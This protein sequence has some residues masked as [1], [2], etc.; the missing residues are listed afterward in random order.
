[1]LLATVLD[2][3]C[4]DNTVTLMKKPIAFG[5][6]MGAYTFFFQDCP[7]LLIHLYFLVFMHDPA[8]LIL[9]A[10]WLVMVSLVV[11]CFAVMISLFNFAMFKQNDFDP[12]AIEKELWKR[13]VK[14][15]SEPEE[16]LIN[17]KAEFLESKAKLKRKMTILAPEPELNDIPTD[18][19]A[20]KD[21]V[22]TFILIFDLL[23]LFPVVATEPHEQCALETQE[24]YSAGEQL[25]VRRHPS[26][27]HG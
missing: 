22:S 17:S 9:H 10:H 19:K 20:G 5:K 7:Q 23:T 4:I 8:S 24:A 16:K 6:L 26:V 25:E 14:D 27:P 2:S 21:Q 18:K 1:M 11:S 12:I 13:R 15:C 3:F